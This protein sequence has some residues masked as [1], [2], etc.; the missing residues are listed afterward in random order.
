M[1][2][3]ILVEKQGSVSMKYLVFLFQFDKENER[4]VWH[5]FIIGIAVVSALV[6]YR[7]SYIIAHCTCDVSRCNET[8]QASLLSRVSF[9]KRESSEL[10]TWS[11]SKRD[12]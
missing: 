10:E 7:T 6:L 4:D 1:T 8:D 2:Y 9:T 11:R 12:T 5:S 3:T